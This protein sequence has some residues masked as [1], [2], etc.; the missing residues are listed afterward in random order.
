VL[1]CKQSLFTVRSCPGIARRENHSIANVT[2][3]SM[4]LTMHKALHAQGASTHGTG[5]AKLPQ[6]GVAHSA[7][8]WC[9]PLLA[10]Q[11]VPALH[12]HDTAHP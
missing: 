12:N 4:G 11:R 8:W 3:S 1:L 6:A 9:G 7:N 10:L 2:C 5:M